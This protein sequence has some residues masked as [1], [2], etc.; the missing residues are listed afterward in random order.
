MPHLR[1]S[2]L[3]SFR[4]SLDGE[5]VTG[6]LSN[7]VRA[8][9]AYLM[10]EGD[11]PHSRDGLA[12]LLWPESP[13]QMARGSLRAALANLR[14]VIQD[15]QA[16]PHFLKKNVH[17][18]RFN[19]ESDHWL[20]LGVFQNLSAGHISEED[21]ASYQ[22]QINRLEQAV[23]LCHGGFME[24]FY[25]EN[26]P[27]FDEWMLVKREQLSRNL[28]ETLYAAIQ[29]FEHLGDFRSARLYAQR[30][31]EL[32]PWDERAHQRL[33]YFWALSGKRAS[34]IA[35]Y[36]TCRRILAEELNMEPSPET[37]QLFKQIMEGKIQG[38]STIDSLSEDST[39]GLISIREEP[40][41][42]QFPVFLQ[43]DETGQ[44]ERQAFF[45]RQK[46]MLCLNTHLKEALRGNGRI[47]FIKGEAG[48]GKTALASEF[49]YQ[50]MQRNPKL[51]AAA[52]RCNAF[53]GSGDPYRLFKS[54]LQMLCGDIESSWDPK[55]I[56]KDHATRLWSLMPLTANTILEAGPNMIDSFVSG[57]DLK[58]RLRIADP[59]SHKLQI[60][61]TEIQNNRSVS[62]FPQQLA[63]V[64]EFTNILQIVSQRY[65]LLLFLDDLQWIDRDSAS[66][67]FHLGRHLPGNR[68]LIIGAY[69]SEE[70]IRDAGEE[71]HPLNP[72]IH[73]LTRL[74]GNVGIDLDQADG[75]AFQDDLLSNW[76]IQL[77]QETRDELYHL[78]NGHPLFARELISDML[79][80]GDL[81]QSEGGFYIKTRQFN[82][83]KMP[84]RIEAVI[85]ERIQRLPEAC[86]KILAV[87]SV[88]GEEF[89]AEVVAKALGLTTGEVIQHLSGPLSKIHRL[90]EARGQLR[91]GVHTYAQYQFRH[92]LF[93]R[94]L[95]QCL[96]P[97]EHSN[98]H[99]A[100]GNALEYFHNIGKVESNPNWKAT[101]IQ[102]ARHFEIAG[103]EEKAADYLLLAADLAR[104]LQSHHEGIDYFQRA[105]QIQKSRKNYEGAARTLIKLGLTHH[106]I[107]EFN[108]ANKAF[109]EGNLLYQY[110]NKIAPVNISAPSRALRIDW[111]ALSTF[112]PALSND[113]ASAEVSDQLFSGLLLLT[114]DGDLVPDLASSW[115]VLDD[116]HR[117]LF[118]LR[119]GLRWSDDTPVTAM[120]FEY[121]WKRVLNP[122]TGSPCASL[123]YC[124]QGAVEYNQTVSGI[125]DQVGIRAIDPTLLQVDLATPTSFFPY[126][127][128]LPAFKP[129]PCHIVEKYGETWTIPQKIQSNGPFRLQDWEEGRMARFERN[130]CYRGD[131]PGNLEQVELYLVPDWHD[132][133]KMYEA[134]ELDVQDLTWFP[135]RE[136]EHLRLT[137]AGEY[138]SKPYL[139]T[140]YIGFDV[141]RL[142]FDDVRVRQAFGLAID[143]DILA[144]VVGRGRL[145]PAKG[146]FVPPGIPGHVEGIGL[147]YNPQKARRLLAEAGYPDGRGFPSLSFVIPQG[148]IIVD[149]DFVRSQWQRNLGLTFDFEILDFLTI[150]QRLM[151][152]PPQLYAFSYV[153]DYPDPDSFLRSPFCLPATRW[154][155]PAFD[156]LVNEA[157]KAT[158]NDERMKLYQQAENIL[159]EESPLLPLVYGR[160]HLLLKPWVKRYP[161]STSRSIHW[162]DVVLSRD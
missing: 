122:A 81:L 49:A 16:N 84:N 35:Q 95:Y 77:N 144:D 31:L 119:E 45:S 55:M 114:F 29:I 136:A 52:G 86:Q 140:G 17:S 155:N 12:G 101:V 126:L 25:L 22:S 20:D 33:M 123:F 53:T 162:K 147:P 70:I 68:I 152:S 92:N 32:E 37:I 34:A 24:G 154:Q 91:I 1:V 36:E 75:R 113:I 72:V 96:D 64:D 130:P 116:G 127:L 11:R 15:E 62:T 135:P 46:E 156:F 7:K 61:L 6:F 89:I 41:I 30:Q 76:S 87:A 143:K 129:V 125:A 42:M 128:A 54:I 40:P 14:K 27:E 137:H 28:S 141:S 85:A 38:S 50:A 132:R 48:S 65:P 80:Q 121:A 13:D 57:N 83:E 9:L 5:P 8:L 104:E 109:E 67:L 43:K 63:L 88:E 97:V 110:A 90:V 111:E 158:D 19:P 118:K 112:D 102:L 73:E 159:I 134:D 44:E 21:S 93:Q 4:A 18:I 51:I 142:P 100:V 149:L 148:A 105:L 60:T 108:Q 82:W 26:C 131:F 56:S 94:Y 2:L 23:K 103:L 66:L 47:V 157:V 145:P 124:I 69:R 107:F 74:F 39:F 139:F 138:I 99:L 153:A 58:D 160:Q 106:T 151:S 115:D 71:E 117:Y 146:G 133:L 150:V 59:S 120:D 10:V 98:L 161:T 78:T 79:I 3:G